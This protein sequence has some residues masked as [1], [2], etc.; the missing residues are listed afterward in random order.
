MHRIVLA[1]CLA[2]TVLAA[3]R[4]ADACGNTVR[5]IV[6]STNESV[7]KAEFLLAQ[8][9]YKQAI[10]TI[11]D[12]FG[13]RALAVHDGPGAQLHQRAQRVL[14]IAVVRSKGAVSIGPGLGGKTDAQRQAAIAWSV[15]TLRLRR[16]ALDDR[17][18]DCILDPTRCTNGEGDPH[19]NADLAEALALQPT[20][21]A[22]AYRLLKDLGDRDLM[23]F[24]EGWA[25][26]AELGRER[27]DLEGA[28][29]A[30]ER[31]KQIA[32]DNLKCDPSE[33]S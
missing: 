26:L 10:S 2:T 3:P 17:N 22:E 7:R 29:K 21:R 8:G 5:R 12:E 13:D 30:V 31:C 1:L 6:D 14:A 11:R 28:K 4:L 24:A 23:P 32:S 19:T 20:G 27:G 33:N 25:L 9:N 15:L 18:V 16:A